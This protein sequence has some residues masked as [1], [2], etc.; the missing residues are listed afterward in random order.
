LDLR[1][2]KVSGLKTD[3]NTMNSLFWL[4]ILAVFSSWAHAENY[5][6]PLLC[7]AEEVSLRA[8]N[9][10]DTPQDFW[11]QDLGTAPFNETYVS[12]KA[13][14]QL[15]IELKDFGYDAKTTAL[16]V[17]THNSTLSF[18]GFCKSTQTSWK[19]ESLNSPWKKISVLNSTPSL[20]LDLAN[21]SHQKNPVEVTVEDI[22]GLTTSQTLLLP[23]EFSK[24]SLQVPIPWGVRSVKIQGLG[25]WTGKAFDFAGR[26][27]ALEEDTVTNPTPPNARYFLFQSQD[28]SSQDSFVV[29]MTN[30]KLIQ[31]T[32]EQIQNP[33]S[34]RLLVARIDKSLEGFNRDFSS[35]TKTPWSWSVVEA[36][37]YADFAHISCDG[38]PGL[39]EERLNSWLVETGSTICFW[40]YRVVRELNP[41]ELKRSP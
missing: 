10:T 7:A 25:R 38:T 2:H 34:A 22:L 17:K 13:K 21:L 1:P 11:F 4:G 20:T 27:I 8:Q 18:Q 31:E 39:V 23:E 37:N 26:E 29:P 6:S 33:Q 15:N 16:S 36:Q 14:S 32:L 30:Q 35:A 41:Q 3:P 19:L 28:A 24:S 12:V 9:P 5:Y 40:S